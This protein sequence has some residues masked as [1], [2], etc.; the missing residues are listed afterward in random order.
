MD[1]T[2][3]PDDLGLILLVGVIC[4]TIIVVKIFNNRRQVVRHVLHGTVTYTIKGY[5][6]DEARKIAQALRDHDDPANEPD[7]LEHRPATTLEK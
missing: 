5:D 2:L 3:N 7:E 4:F 1:W 6:G